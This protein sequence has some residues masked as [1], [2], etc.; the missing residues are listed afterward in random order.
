MGRA[1]GGG[2][3]GWHWHGRGGPPRQGEAPRSLPEAAVD[4]LTS[5]EQTRAGLTLTTLPGPREVL[6]LVI[7][8]ERAAGGR[9][10]RQMGWLHAAN[11]EHIAGFIARGQH[12]R[13]SRQIPL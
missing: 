12:T 2:G 10:R 3:T 8:R 5:C 9:K 4:C 6:I 11:K 7:F 1:G 13:P